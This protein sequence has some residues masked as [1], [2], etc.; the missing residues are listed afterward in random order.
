MTL[1]YRDYC[2]KQYLEAMGE[3]T[4]CKDINASSIEDYLILL[5]QKYDNVTTVRTNIQVIKA[6]TNFGIQ[7]GYT[8]KI[9]I[10]IPKA[11]ETK[12]E[13]YSDEDLKK[14]LKKAK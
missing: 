1:K 5:N 3:D 8:K 4:L 14:L 7:R 6:F 13:T 10:L 12:K 2:L 9:K 11:V